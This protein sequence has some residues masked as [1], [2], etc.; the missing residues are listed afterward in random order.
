[1]ITTNSRIGIILFPHK[2]ADDHDNDP[3]PALHHFI[4]MS[5]NTKGCKLRQVLVKSA[6]NHALLRINH[7]MHLSLSLSQNSRLDETTMA[8]GIRIKSSVKRCGTHE[9]D[10]IMQCSADI[11]R[12]WEKGVHRP[13]PTLTLTLTLEDYFPRLGKFS[14]IDARMFYDGSRGALNLHLIQGV[15]C[16]VRY[17]DLFRV[18]CGSNQKKRIEQ[19]VKHCFRDLL[20][21]KRQDPGVRQEGI[22]SGKIIMIQELVMYLMID[23]AIPSSRECDLLEFPR[24]LG[25]IVHEIIVNLVEVGGRPLPLEIQG[26]Q[27]WTCQVNYIRGRRALNIRPDL[28]RSAW[29]SLLLP[30]ECFHRNTV[31]REWFWSLW[32]VDKGKNL[33]QMIIC[34]G[35][36]ITEWWVH[37]LTGY[38]LRLSA[39]NSM[40]LWGLMTFL[41][42]V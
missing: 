18:Y 24:I 8:T 5:I 30:G 38:S 33:H 13:E 9:Y 31:T 23:Q 26:I 22:I 3:P 10:S 7:K 16:Q 39:V 12:H 21:R 41:T 32:K 37:V 35:S 15:C 4:S 42:S 1:M 29:F 6:S 25:S 36:Q 40:D 19:L 2:D 11:S 34:S 27:G 28:N 20:E 14:P 17:H